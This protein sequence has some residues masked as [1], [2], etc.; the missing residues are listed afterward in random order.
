MLFPS[1]FSPRSAM[2][3]GKSVTYGS[4]IAWIVLGVR[5]VGPGGHPMASLGTGSRGVRTQAVG[6]PLMVSN[7]HTA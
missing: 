7:F 3:G 1:R 6:F 5:W 2:V 4:G